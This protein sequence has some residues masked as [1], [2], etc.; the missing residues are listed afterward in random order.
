[1]FVGQT[2]IE[3]FIERTVDMATGMVLAWLVYTYYIFPRVDTLTPLHV[4]SVFTAISFFRGLAWRRFFNRGLHKV[5][6]QMMVSLWYDPEDVWYCGDCEKE[7]HH[8]NDGYT[9][10]Q[11]GFCSEGC[12][13][14]YDAKR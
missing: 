10:H 6:H 5:V 14:A 4:V 13:D 11:V 2:R 8:S 9:R 7:L 1:M 3:S 12:A